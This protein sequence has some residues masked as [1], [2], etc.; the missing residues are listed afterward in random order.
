[1]AVVPAFYPQQAQAISLE[2]DA[3]LTVDPIAVQTPILD[4]VLDPVV[5]PSLE[6]VLEPVVD[7]VLD[8]VVSGLVSLDG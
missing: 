4:P 3:G 1:M 8:P 2:A 7:P 5:D 6:P